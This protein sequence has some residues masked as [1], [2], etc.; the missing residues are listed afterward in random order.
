MKENYQNGDLI[1]IVEPVENK[2]NL[3][4]FTKIE[5]GKDSLPETSKVPSLDVAKVLSSYG[6]KLVKII[7]V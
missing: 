4:K 7:H 1:V 5:I 2:P 3:K 6:E